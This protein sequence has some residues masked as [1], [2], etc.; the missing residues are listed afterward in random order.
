MYVFFRFS[1]VFFFRVLMSGGWEACA[2]SRGDGA[3]TFM[4]SDGG[5][6]VGDMKDGNFHGQGMSCARDDEL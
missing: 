5:M 1:I 3:G 6:Y 4:F 2:V